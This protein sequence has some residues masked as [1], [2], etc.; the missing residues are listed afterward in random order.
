MPTH[1]IISVI[2]PIYNVKEYLRK[3]LDSLSAQTFKEIEFLLIDDGSS[4]S[5]GEIADQYTTDSRFCVFHTENHGLA[6]VR[7]FGIEKAR[8]QY[9][10]FVDS[11]DYVASEFCELPYKAAIDADADLV[12]FGFVEERRHNEKVLKPTKEIPSGI[13]DELTAYECG[14]VAAWNKL[15]KKALFIDVRFPEGR[16]SEDTATTYKIVHAANRIYYLNNYLYYYNLSRNDSIVHTPSHKNK[17]DAFIAANERHEVLVSYGYPEGKLLPHLYAKAIGVLT[18]LLPEDNELHIQAKE[19]V[20]SIKG[21]PRFLSWRQK[22]ALIVW[23]TDKKLFRL[24]CKAT[25]R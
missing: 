24:F 13:I 22:V 19:I 14:D 12:I 6:A 16:I 8:G 1:P 2:V 21:V 11:D 3:C 7:N 15:Y 17:M 10:M 25:G 5:S 4:D 23:K 18:C 9:I 20:D